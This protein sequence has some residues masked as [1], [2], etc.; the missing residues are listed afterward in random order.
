LP[1]PRRIA[2]ESQAQFRSSKGWALRA[3]PKSDF[4][5]R[6]KRDRWLNF[7]EMRVPRVL[8]GG[9]HPGLRECR[10][11]VFRSQPDGRS[12]KAADAAPRAFS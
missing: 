9:H 3:I 5:S 8:G 7:A 6:S 12:A 10:V 4:I 2:F 1:V 11:I